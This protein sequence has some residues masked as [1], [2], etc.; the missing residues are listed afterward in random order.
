MSRGAFVGHC[1]ALAGLLEVTAEKP[2]NVT[3][4]HDFPDTK[5]HHFLSSSVAIEAPM[6]RLAEDP[7]YRV[8]QGILAAVEASHKAQTGGNAQLGIILLFSPVAKA[9]GLVN[10]RLTARSLRTTLSAVLRATDDQ[11]ALD[12][13]KAINYGH[14]GGLNDVKELDVRKRSTYDKLRDKGITLLDWMKVG[15]QAN[16]VCHE[17]ATNYKIT[18]N[19]G[20]PTLLDARRKGLQGAIVHTYLTILSENV[21]THIAGKW[22]QGLSEQVSK[23]AAAIV[24]RGSVWTKDGS[25][26][27]RRLTNY[28]RKGRINPGATADLTASTIFAALL[29]GLE[30]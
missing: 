11:D 28:L 8:G 27:V 23:K 17:Y 20:L 3:P 30:M 1:A 21:D 6:R 16:S 25:A 14:V 18:F 12:A 9:A 26:S 13:F 29:T 5:F 15:A 10:G 19:L 7:D 2:G 22:G 4:T 24:R